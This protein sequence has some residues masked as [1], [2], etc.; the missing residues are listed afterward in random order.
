[1]RDF[2]AN[3]DQEELLK[4]LLDCAAAG[5]TLE[6][7]RRGEKINEFTSLNY[8]AA[9]FPH[10]FPRGQ[11]QYL[12]E[13]PWTPKPADWFRHLLRYR[14]MRFARD[15][16]FRYHCHDTIVR[17]RNSDV[18]RAFVKKQFANRDLDDLH[19]EIASGKTHICDALS[20]FVNTI[21]GNRAYWRRQ[22]NLLDSYDFFLQ[23]T[24]NQTWTVF[25]TLSHADLHCPDLHRMLP[26]HER[27]MNSDGSRLDG[28]D[29][30]TDYRMRR[31]A[32]IEHP[33]IVAYHFYRRANEFRENVLKQVLGFD[34]F[35]ARFELQGRG[36]T[37]EHGVGRAKHAP[38]IDDLIMAGAAVL[39]LHDDDVP[40]ADQ[41]SA[42]HRVVDWVVKN[43]NVTSMHP[44][45]TRGEFDGPSRDDVLRKCFIDLDDAEMGADSADQFALCQRCM[46]HRCNREDCKKPLSIKCTCRGNHSLPCDRCNPPC[47]KGFDSEMLC[48]CVSCTPTT[49]TAPAVAC[50]CAPGDEKG[51]PSACL[52]YARTGMCATRLFE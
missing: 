15:R 17:H 8:L 23:A 44:A 50:T 34:D 43:L 32:L 38:Q 27:Y 25:Y 30:R 21:P 49:A 12:G 37:H 33:H 9:A 39:S 52:V 19:A 40:T 47:K 31:E 10:L 11:F 29:S 46:L 13:R 3:T 1:M 28:V 35:C 16:R 42:V 24:Y 20:R 22:S 26:G 45:A 36:I 5:E 41:M 2:D 14:G 51:L 18:S 7:P 6:W 48:Q 4:Q